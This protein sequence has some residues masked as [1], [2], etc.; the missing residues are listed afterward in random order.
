MKMQF[1][2]DL[3]SL[4]SLSYSFDALKT[5]LEYLATRL[6]RQGEELDKVSRYLQ[7]NCPKLFLGKLTRPNKMCTN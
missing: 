2:V 7:L 6:D 4:F 3:N 1:P 5:A